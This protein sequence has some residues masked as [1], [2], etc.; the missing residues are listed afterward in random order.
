[1]SGFSL[2]HRLLLLSFYPVCLAC[3][4]VE[5]ESNCWC[6]VSPVSYAAFY[7]VLGSQ[8]GLSVAALSLYVEDLF[9]R[10]LLRPFRLAFWVLGVASFVVACVVDRDRCWCRDYVLN[11]TEILGA[12]VVM[13]M[14]TATLIFDVF[15]FPIKRC[16]RGAE[17]EE[18]RERE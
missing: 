12:H 5:S 14:A 10:R 1:M 6:E 11:R 2:R 8:L 13:A 4:I 16:L 9:R 3:T 15:H 17:G 7:F 18:E